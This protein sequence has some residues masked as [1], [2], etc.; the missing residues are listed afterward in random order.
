MLLTLDLSTISHEQKLYTENAR[1]HSG[2][3]MSGVESSPHSRLCSLLLSLGSSSWA[4]FINNWLSL[5]EGSK[6]CQFLSPLEKLL[7]CACSFHF[8]E[9]SALLFPLDQN[10]REFN[11]QR[12]TP[13]WE[14]LKKNTS[15]MRWDSRCNEFPIHSVGY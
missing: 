10:H 15:I 9:A 2:G 8:F 4:F 1:D 13:F 12:I 3:S 6:R 5:I 7:F 14:F 11:Y